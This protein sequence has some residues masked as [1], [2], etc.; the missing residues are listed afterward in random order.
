MP[1]PRRRPARDDELLSAS[2]RAFA[3][4]GYF[5]TSTARVAA[6]MGVSQPY[7][8]RTFGSKLELFVRT[9]AHAAGAITRTFREASGGGFDAQRLGA[10]YRLLVLS[11]PADVLVW[12]HAFSAATAEPTIGAE[13]RRQFDEVYRTLRDAGGSDHE[14]WAFM[15]RG[16]LINNLLLM[17]APRYADDYDFGPLVDLVFGPPPESFRGATGAPRLDQE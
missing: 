6:E 16:M 1:H 11:H 3:A 5:G 17:E 9:H 10:A 4:R 12:A 13:S 7:V 2:V 8:I 15:G 14:L